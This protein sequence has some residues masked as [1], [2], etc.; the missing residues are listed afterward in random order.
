EKGERQIREV[1]RP[2][3][4]VATGVDAV[5]V[6]LRRCDDG[7]GRPIREC[8]ED[9]QRASIEARR[10]LLRGRCGPR[11]AACVRLHTLGHDVLE[12]PSNETVGPILSLLRR[13]PERTSDE[14]PSGPNRRRPVAAVCLHTYAGVCS[15][16]RDAPEEHR[17]PDRD[18]VLELDLE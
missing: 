1:A 6:E 10:R 3:E 18:D 5:G 7:S 8:L 17:L 4:A 15:T 2:D 14:P 16:E 13:P 9:E 12:P 11:D